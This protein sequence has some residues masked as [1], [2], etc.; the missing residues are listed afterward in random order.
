METKITICNYEHQQTEYLK[1]VVG[2]WAGENNITVKID[3]FESAEN[4]KT[5]WNK[6]QR[7]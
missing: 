3:M 1:T 2:K 5:E 4:F 7:V 6:K